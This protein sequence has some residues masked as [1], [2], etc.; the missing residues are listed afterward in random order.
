M[1][2]S[3]GKES[4]DW[5]QRLRD[6]RDAKRRKPGVTK[7][8]KRG[9]AGTIGAVLL[10]SIFLFAGLG[11][12]WFMF[13]KPGLVLLDAQD[14]PS[15]PATVTSSQLDS[16]TDS[17]GSTTYKL[18]ISFA[19]EYQGRRYT[20]YTYDAFSGMSSS[21]YKNKKKII[22]R[23]PVGRHATAYVNP[24]DPGVALLY[25]GWSHNIWFAAIP[26]L[27]VLIG[28]GG[29]I[30]MLWSRGGDSWAT[31]HAK[32]SDRVGPRAQDEWLP[33][34]A[35][36]DERDGAIDG[37]ARSDTNTVSPERSRW[38][39]LGFTVF[40]AL[41]WN[42]VVAIAVVS[43]LKGGV[44]SNKMPLL[45]MI[46]FVLIGVGAL[47]AVVYMLLAMSNPVV[48]MH[49]DPRVMT[50]GEPLRVAWSIDGRAGR[51]DR[52]TVTVEGAERATYTRG[53]DRI[54]DEHVFFDH[55]LYD[56]RAMDPRDPL[57]REGEAELDL[58]AGA[59]H[60]LDAG[61][62]KIVWRIKVKGEIPRWPDVKDEYEFAVV[63][64]GAI[65][66]VPNV[67]GMF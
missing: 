24:K 21:G 36:S 31:K 2:F 42:T 1:K 58:P 60:S 63:P 6:K 19:Y 10:L 49:F 41:I 45:F 55:T 43:M 12:G 62:N 28:G 5:S 8:A 25:R 50:W 20:A 23:H 65:D 64:A 18:K 51:F 59:M 17:E 67:R 11:F 52:L 32:R 22:D 48:R 40:F 35:R 57:A 56:A 26:L 3:F 34:F 61:H 44:S 4:G 33:G 13:A 29:L 54:T 46:P 7:R 15:V 9:K 53:T 16:H 47:I 39:K 66:G 27:S 30:G 37:Q 38:G 14:W